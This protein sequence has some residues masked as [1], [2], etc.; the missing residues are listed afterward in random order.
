VFCGQQDEDLE[1]GKATV[2]IAVQLLGLD[3]EH[4]D[5]HAPDV[6]SRNPAQGSRHE[7]GRAEPPAPAIAPTTNHGSS[8]C[9]STQTAW[10]PRPRTDQTRSSVVTRAMTFGHPWQ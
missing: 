3:G 4:R 9:E 5:M 8:T 10:T 7:P 2:R 6:S 1:L